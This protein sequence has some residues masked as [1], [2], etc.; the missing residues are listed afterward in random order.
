MLSSILE[1]KGDTVGAEAEYQ[2]AVALD[3]KNDIAHSNLGVLVAA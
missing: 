2:T 3:P 1:A